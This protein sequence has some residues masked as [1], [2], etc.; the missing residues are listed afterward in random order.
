MLIDI[1][2]TATSAD[3]GT[4]LAQVHDPGQTRFE[5]GAVKLLCKSKDAKAK[6][7]CLKALMKQYISLDDVRSCV[8]QDRV[9]SGLKVAYF[10]SE[11]DKQ[12]AT[13]GKRF[14]LRF[15]LYD[16]WGQPLQFTN[17]EEEIS[18]S[19]SINENNPQGAVLWGIRS[20]ITRAGELQLNH[21]MISQ[22]GKVSFRVA[23]NNGK[24]SIA[25]F[26]LTVKADPRLKH[27]TRCVSFFRLLSCPVDMRESEWLSYFPRVKGVVSGESIYELLVC[28]ETFSR[29]HVGLFPMPSGV[30]WLE[31][32]AGIEAI[33]TG[34]NL[35]MMEQSFEQRLELSPSSSIKLKDIRRAY[36]R[37]SLQWHPDRWAGM[38]IYAVVVQGAFQLINEAYEK[39][40]LF[41]QNT[42]KLND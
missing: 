23:T 2:S 25:S 26:S 40:S 24:D 9:V 20:N 39:L 4:C 27:T 19:A 10:L 33:W 7:G 21:L 42:T 15:K 13:A 28:S 41:Y 5:D 12:E 22:P 32:K 34:T 16:Q 37:K 29:W 18:L 14:S 11:D 38:P 8:S 36:Y 30:V 17:P 1:C 35:P 31:F 6:L 3:A